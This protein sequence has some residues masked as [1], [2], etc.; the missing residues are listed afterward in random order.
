MRKYPKE[1]NNL[2]T[3]IIIGEGAARNGR[4]VIPA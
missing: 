1:S 4:T 3:L 2:L